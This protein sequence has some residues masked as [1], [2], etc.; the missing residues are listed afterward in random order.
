MAHKA[1]A[2]TQKRTRPRQLQATL[3]ELGFLA[4]SLAEIKRYLASH[5]SLAKVVPGVCAQARREFGGD[6]ELILTLYKDPEINDRH[7]TIYVRLPVY[8]ASITRRMDRVTEPFEKEL[9]SVS[10]FLLV[11]TD[12]RAPGSPHAL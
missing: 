3:A 4:P 2:G 7:L 12:F 11:A 9:C 8:D 10:G 6:A 1:A 5:R